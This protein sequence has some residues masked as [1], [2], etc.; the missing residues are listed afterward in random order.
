MEQLFQFIRRAIYAG[1]LGY[2]IFLLEGNNLWAYAEDVG[3]GVGEW[4]VGAVADEALWAYAVPLF[5]VWQVS[6]LD[7]FSDQTAGFFN[8]GVLDFIP[9]P[10]QAEVGSY[11]AYGASVPF[12]SLTLNNLGGTA[13]LDGVVEWQFWDGAS[14]L[15]IPG[16]VDGTLSYGEVP[17]DGQVVSWDNPIVGWATT[18]LNGVGPY[19]WIRSYVTTMYSNLIEYNDGN[20]KGSLEGVWSEGAVVGEGVFNTVF[21]TAAASVLSN[22][23]T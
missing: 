11:C 8:V 12:D 21:S 16:I 17:A 22:D 14:W 3:G 18:T 6:E 20:P 15:P 19:Y 10:D 2:T 1:V 23:N 4:D 9:L 5:H 13:G 7:V